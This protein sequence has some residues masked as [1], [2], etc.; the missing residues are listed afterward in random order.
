LG[1]L[2]AAE[3]GHHGLLGAADR[4]EEGR[5]AGHDHEDDDGPEPV[6]RG[7]IVLPVQGLH[8]AE[9]EGEARQLDLGELRE[10]GELEVELHRR[11]VSSGY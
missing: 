7:A 11:S 2:R 4:E 6:G 9:V 8:L 5:E 1:E 10:L 3:L